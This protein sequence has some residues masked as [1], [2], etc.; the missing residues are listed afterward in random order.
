M[1]LKLREIYNKYSLQTGKSYF[2]LHC[3]QL[4][5][6]VTFA[7]VNVSTTWADFETC[8]ARMMRC[9]ALLFIFGCV[10]KVL[11]SCGAQSEASAPQEAAGCGCGN[12]KRAAAVDSVEKRTA[13]GN[14]HAAAKYSRDAN[15]RQSEAPRDEKELQSQVIYHCYQVKT[16]KFFSLIFIVHCRQKE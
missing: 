16:K 11:C 4:T 14:T 10:S 2:L 1:L 13:S 12:L 5:D 3:S 9:L 6:H 7:E 8:S 15:E